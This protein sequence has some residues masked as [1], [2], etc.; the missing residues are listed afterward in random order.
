MRVP[1]AT[2]PLSLAGLALLW[3]G[4]SDDASLLSSDVLVVKPDKSFSEHIS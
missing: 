2:F 4:W 1:V 3:S